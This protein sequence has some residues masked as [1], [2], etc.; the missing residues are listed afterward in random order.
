MG[1]WKRLAVTKRKGISQARRSFPSG[2]ASY[3]ASMATFAILYIENRFR[4]RNSFTLLKPFLE[5]MW[6]CFAAFVS[7]SRVS[8][9][10]HH[11]E[12]VLFGSLLGIVITLIIGGHI[13]TW[14]NN[15]NTLCTKLDSN[16]IVP[17]GVKNQE[18]KIV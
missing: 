3:V 9:Y 5:L 4:T 10:Y 2:H 16:K 1:D 6:I 14:L 13:M 11:L 15:L 18:N 8:D 17:S 12:D 7:M